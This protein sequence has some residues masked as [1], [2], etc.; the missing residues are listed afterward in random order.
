MLHIHTDRPAHIVGILFDQ[1][2]DLPYFKEGAVILVFCVR[3]QVHNHVCT[4]RFAFRFRHCVAVG[5]FA[6]PPGRLLFPVFSGDDS[7]FVRHHKGRVESH[8]ELADNRKILVLRIAELAF[9]RVGTAFCNHTEI[10]LGFF[11][12]HANTVVAHGDGSRFLV[13]HDINPE[14]V[15]IQPDLVIRQ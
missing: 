3:F 7:H 4:G 11:L 6:F 14:I 8:A 2:F 15:P 1:C 9:E 10:I 12:R 5:T 13:E